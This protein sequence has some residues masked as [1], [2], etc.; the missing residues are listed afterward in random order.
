MVLTDSAYGRRFIDQGSKILIPVSEF[1]SS[2]RI[3]TKSEDWR[4]SCE[5]QD[6]VTRSANRK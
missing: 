2:N 1:S 6:N 3:Q 4:I 5:G